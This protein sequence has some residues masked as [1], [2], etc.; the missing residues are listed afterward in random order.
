VNDK[1]PLVGKIFGGYRITEK[2]AQGGMAAVYRGVDRRLGRDVAIKLVL[3]G[4]QYSEVFLKRFRREIRALGKLMHPHIVPLLD[5]GSI[6]GVPY[7]V[8]PYLSG[9]TIQEMIGKVWDWYDA[10]QIIIPIGQSIAYAHS[11][12]IIHRDIKPANILLTESGEPMLS[13]FGLMKMLKEEQSADLTGSGMVGTPDFMAPEQWVG[14]AVPQTDIYA[15]GIIFYVMITGHL[16]YEAASA[17]EIMF[18]HI[19]ESHVPP[20]KH[21]PDIPI[22]VEMVIERALRKDYQKRYATMAEFV[23]EVEQLTNRLHSREMANNS[24]SVS[25]RSGKVGKFQW[26]AFKLRL[27][28]LPTWV[29]AGVV[30]FIL[31]FVGILSLYF[32]SQNFINWQD[33]VA[34]AQAVSVNTTTPD[35]LALVNEPQVTE[36]ATI[37]ATT[38]PTRTTASTRQPLP[39]TSTST[40]A[41]T[42][43]PTNSPSATKDLSL[44]IGSTKVSPVDEMLMMYIPE[45]LFE[46]G[47]RDEDEEA[48][49]DE[50]PR[51]TVYLDAFWMDQTEVTVGQYMQCVDAGACPKPIKIDSRTRGFYFGNEPFLNHPV[52]NVNWYQANDYCLWAGRRLPTEAEW[53]KAAT[54]QQENGLYPWGS[55]LDCSLA[56]YFQGPGGCKGDTNPVDEYQNGASLYGVLGL[57]GNVWE[58]VSDWYDAEYYS[59]SPEENPKGPNLGTY[60]VTRGGTFSQA[61]SALRITNRGLNAPNVYRDNGGFRCVMDAE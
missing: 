16:P 5:F 35:Q 19:S 7:L 11:N 40:A 44:E 46:M 31:A 49:D 57:A 36:T 18:K 37:T 45:G 60:N 58:W 56:N 15:L 29:W 47:A 30:F 48:K 23:T 4:R 10:A 17:P 43:T 21:V 42:I 50:K 20:R 39:S 54:S 55:R 52:I 1:D 9:G 3:G 13:D 24:K 51:H 14:E 41:V 2:I 25:R 59:K 8:M 34:T 27:R 33:S 12:G 28:S 53:E 6:H 38:Q 61:P 22:E 32:I 26:M